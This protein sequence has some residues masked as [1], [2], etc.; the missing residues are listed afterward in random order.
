MSM[1]EHHARVTADLAHHRLH[2]AQGA[3]PGAGQGIIHH[4]IQQGFPHIDAVFLQRGFILHGLQAFADLV[5]AEPG[6]QAHHRQRQ[7]Q[8]Q[9]Q[10]AGIGR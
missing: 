2:H 4:Q 3:T 6:D 7:P 10:I 1:V 9:Y 8:G 5:P